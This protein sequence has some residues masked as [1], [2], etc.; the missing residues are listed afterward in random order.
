MAARASQFRIVIFGKNDNEKTALSNFITGKKNPIRQT[1]TKKSIVQGEWRKIPV[2]VAKTTDLFSLPVEKVKLE[3]KMCVARCPPGPN[4]LLLIVNPSDFTE[5][6]RRT[7]KSILCLFGGDAFKYSMVIT[8]QKGEAENSAMNQFIQNCRKRHCTLDFDKKDF[9]DSDRETLMGEMEKIVAYNRGGHLNYTETADLVEEPQ[10]ESGHG[11]EEPQIPSQNYSSNLEL[12]DRP[13]VDKENQQSPRLISPLNPELNENP[14]ASIKVPQSPKL[15]PLNLVLF[16]RFG[17]GKTS[18]ANAILGERKV[19]SES[20]EC[21]KN[22]AEVCGRLVSLVELP[23]LYGKPQEDTKKEAF[24]SISLC[25]PEGVHAFILVLPLDPPT[26]ED[27]K[28]VKTIKDTLRSQIDNYTM[29]LF[30][31]ESDPTHPDVVKYV[32]TNREIQELVQSFFGRYIVFNIND[33]EQIPQLLDA[34]EKMKEE[35]STG[36]KIT[37][38]PKPRQ[39]FQL[40]GLKPEVMSELKQKKHFQKIQKNRQIP[41]KEIENH[42]RIVLIGKT[43]SGKSATANTIL[44]RDCFHSKA[45]MKSVTK[46]CQKETT[47]I[48]GHPV[49]V[50]D[51]PGLFDTSLSNDDVKQELMKCVTMLAPGPHVFLLVLQVGRFTEEEKQT[52][53]L[54]K[55][56]FGKNST[57]FIIILFT[58]GDDL[59]NQTVESYMEEDSEGFLKKLTAEC[60]GRYHVFNNNDPSN[61]SQV[62]QLLTKIES[63]VRKNGGGYYTSEMFKEAEAAIQ[64]EM[65]KIMKK[66]EEEIERQKKD[67]E[68]E[69][70]KKLQEAQQKIEQERAARE[71]ALQEK[72]ELIKKEEEEKKRMEEKRAEEEKERK[73][74]EEIQQQQW[75]QKEKEIK[76]K[77][78]EATY[79]N[80]RNEEIRK[81]IEAWEK[82][83]KEW[84]KK[85]LREEQLRLKEQAR[86][87]K[88]RAEYEQEKEEHERRRKE[89]DQLR[90]EQEEK[91][92]RELQQN[93]KKQVDE[94]RRKNQEE[95]RKQAEEFNEFR[96]RYTTDFAVVVAKHEREVENMKL[97][98]QKNNDLMIQQLRRNKAY[99]KDFDLMKKRQEEE[100][101]ELKRYTPEPKQVD[102]L[103]KAHEEEINEWIQEHVRIATENKS[104]SIL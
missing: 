73:R 50:V 43:G 95:A 35:A 53:E 76:S 82:E 85:R 36:F 96:Q 64:K 80:Q 49:V 55:N 32:K 47:E 78:Q 87:E 13:R 15:K 1:L 72:E 60:R 89:E 9:L 19:G 16:G 29:I 63:M 3:M 2:T 48:N 40:P 52:V 59:K 18:A 45:S 58:R 61:R 74:R 97:K 90:K 17:V 20:F 28:E 30:T 101:N 8:T 103:Q 12:Y 56:F 91:E 22:E 33:Q 86:L 24:K 34:V 51:T 93:L 84:E 41:I 88:L 94:M 42:L 102:E 4:V 92:W 62:S 39:K 38:I 44:G 37:M 10:E 5:D 6:D 69:H 27:K 70:E 65:Q 100:M 98:Q 68:K 46:L 79:A 67:L 26:S 66:K 57:N 71:K 75:V 7:L 81:E 14:Q 54:I 31:V 104:C 77:P 21:V 11:T 23:A 99:Q 25:D 83:Q